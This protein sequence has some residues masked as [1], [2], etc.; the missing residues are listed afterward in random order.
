MMES[1]DYVKSMFDSTL[2]RDPKDLAKAL[3]EG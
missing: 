3:I 2:T 1:D